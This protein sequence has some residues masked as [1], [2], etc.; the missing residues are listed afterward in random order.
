MEVRK[1]LIAGGNTTAL[2]WGCDLG[3]EVTIAKDLLSTVEQ[4]GFVSNKMGVDSL[5]MM[6]GELCVNATIALA[7]LGGSEGSLAVECIEDAPIRY[8]NAQGTTTVFLPLEYKLLENIVL[9][10][11]IGYACTQIQ[12]E[13]SKQTLSLLAERFNVPAFGSVFYKD[14]RIYPTVYVAATNSLCKE[15]ACGSG[16]VA[17]HIVTGA[18]KLMQPSGGV[19][20]IEKLEGHTFVVRAHVSE[21]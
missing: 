19:I 8:E 14:S 7:S 17:V 5:S 9:F 10:E 1:F 20:E 16:S 12:E 11:N 4:V 13:V 2:V 15:T 3:G 18:Q 21:I 6:G